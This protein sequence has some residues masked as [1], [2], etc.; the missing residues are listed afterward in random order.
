MQ[1]IEHFEQLQ[2]IKETPEGGPQGPAGGQPASGTP[3]LEA[4]L[5][6]GLHHPNVVQTYKYA[7]RCAEVF[8]SLLCETSVE[9]LVCMQPS[10]LE[11]LMC[12]PLVIR[13]SCCRR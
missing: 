13:M 8:L 4:V 1:V 2:L 12:R 7:T 10:C 6:H 3:L 11:T 5:G 9:Q